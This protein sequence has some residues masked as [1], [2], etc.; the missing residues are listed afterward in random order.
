MEGMSRR[1]KLKRVRA[2]VKLVRQLGERLQE[3]NQPVRAVSL[4]GMPRGG[5]LPCGLDARLAKKDA[6]ERM[7]EH[8]SAR[9]HRYEE[10]ARRE[11]DTMNPDVY[12]FCLMYYLCAMTLEETVETL[13]RSERQC[14]RY[15][16]AAERERPAGKKACAEEG[17]PDAR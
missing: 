7:I 6:M 17:A 1:D 16:R 15:K 9:L 13:G 3:M 5:G 4:T 8:E 12:A 2:Q 14:L 11:M 10:E